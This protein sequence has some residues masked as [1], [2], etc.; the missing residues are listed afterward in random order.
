MSWMLAGYSNCGCQEFFM[1]ETDNSNYTIILDHAIFEISDDVFL[2]FEIMGSKWRFIGVSGNCVLGNQGIQTGTL[3]SS[4][5]V[6][7]VS[8][9]V[10]SITILVTEF[11][12]DIRGIK[13][14]LIGDPATVSIGSDT[15]NDIIIAGIPLISRHHVSITVSRG[16][17]TIVDKSK[18]GTFVNGKRIRE[19]SR[20]EYGD[21]IS[22]FGIQLIWLGNIIG[23]GGKCGQIRCTLSEIALEKA[24]PD[25][26][27]SISPKIEKHYFRRSPRNL[28][29]FYSEKIEIDAPPQAQK[30]SRRPLLLTIGP[31][32]T[33]TLP[34][35]LGTT[36]AIWGSRKSGA[37]A[38]LYMYTGI[39]IAVLSAVIGTIWALINLNYSKKQEV[40]SEHIRIKKYNDYLAG[41]EQEITEKYTYNYQ[42]LNYI[43]PSADRCARYTSSVPDLWNRNTSHDDFLFLRLGTGVLPFQCSIIAP[44]KKFSLQEDE[45]LTKS[46]ELADKFKQLKDAPLGIDLNDKSLVG[47]VGQSKKE[48]L[49]IM[50]NLVVQA[51]AN[52]CYTDLKMVFLFDGNTPSSFADWS[53]AKWLPHV[54]SPDRK[55]RYFASNKNERNEVCF[56]LANILRIRAEEDSFPAG[57]GK[58]A[59]HYIVFVSSPELLEGMPVAKYLL[60]YNGGLGVTTVLLADRFEQLP[61]G[62]VDI[63]ENNQEFSGFFNIGHDTE[64]RIHIDFD[65]VTTDD[66][67]RFA[68][69]ISAVEVQE[70]ESGSEIPESLTFL[71]MYHVNTLEELNISDRWAKNRTYETLR[72]PIGQKSGGEILSLDIHERFHG[73]HGLVAG[74]TGS[75]KSEV[76]QTYILSL[77]VNFSPNDVAF[78]LIDFKGGGMAN[79]FSNLPHIA[80]YIS[81]LSG[82]QI[83]RA[84]VSI[85]SENK[86][87]QRIFGEYGVNHI[88]QYTRLFKNGEATIPIPRLFIIID[89]FAELKRNEP[90]FMGELISVAQVGR[91]LGVHLILATQKPSG[92]V[93]DNIWSNTR[94]KLCL[95]VQD[96]QD[97]NDVLH[98]PDA[99]YLTQAGRCYM[100]IGNDEI[101]EL[102]QSGWSGAI[103]YDDSSVGK[104]SIAQLWSNIG[105]SAITGANRKSSHGLHSGDKEITQLSALV[106]YLA[107]TAD[108]LFASQER[109]RLW[110]PILPQE[111][112]LFDIFK[113]H[114]FNGEKWPARISETSLSVPVGVYD[115]P[116]NQAQA[117]LIVDLAA[118]GHLV[119]CGSVVSGK[120]TFVQT[121]LFALT[122]KYSPEYI[123]IYILDYS[124]HM[125]E[126]FSELAHVGGVVFDTQADKTEKLF[127]LLSNMIEERKKAFCGGSYT[128]YVKTHGQNMP[129]ILVVI[130][131]YANF[132]D[133]TENKYENNLIA[134]SREGANYGI[135]LI[136]TAGGFGAG[137]LQNR[138]AENFRSIVCLEMGDRFKYSEVLR[139]NH[140]DILPEGNVK[141]RGLVNVG[142]RI[143]EFQTAIA[144]SAA[145]DYQRSEKLKV[146]F[147]EMNRVWDGHRARHIPTIPENPTWEDF[148]QHN[149]EITS[150]S[151]TYMLPFA[152][153]AKDATIAHIDLSR[154]YC[155]LVSGKARTGKT[156]LLKVIAASAALL[157]SERYIVDFSGT[158]LRRFASENQAFYISDGNELFAALKELLAK[159]KE[160]NVQKQELLAA[161]VDESDIYE[162]MQGFPPI[163]LFVDSLDDFMKIIYT[164]PE[165]IGA[166]AGFIENITEKGYLHNIYI[167]AGYD[168]SSATHSV[169]R[170]AF[171]NFVSYKTG[172]HL[173]GNTAAQR[174]FDFSMIPYSEQSKATK[175]GTGLIPPDIYNPVA[176]SV[177]IPLLKG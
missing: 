17:C 102:F 70:T 176:Q 10:E 100:Q 26:A 96:K 113:E 53:F 45:L 97:S 78:F 173:G 155:W 125:L 42:N 163:F 68:R 56:S 27:P 164:P 55:C 119:I 14:Y 59:P 9:G 31:S 77:A 147:S 92:T 11:S 15:N 72:V 12:A 84:M 71:D 161:G 170:K 118:N 16:N 128:Q 76:L 126:P 75:G 143:L 46:V 154:T 123:N 131:N 149:A 138:I 4:G 89:E 54:W 24:A 153:N 38:G 82:N 47:I 32:L 167:I 99:A 60:G 144:I 156:T 20:I 13:K 52:I 172:I 115:D 105:L 158:K 177:I 120:S 101:Y 151:A 74:T 18:N 88:D 73:P 87:R 25:D 148:L 109:F 85:K 36:V 28:P 19:R 43:Y 91:S 130:D 39:I 61:N 107:A 67:E 106:N 7:Y 137:D 159:F 50:R 33:M 83:H 8:V 3:I 169:G 49:I 86:R 48:S 146:C 160:R 168:S 29:K 51:A 22:L 94:F 21:C 166:M 69:T 122:H 65:F 23:V 114:S 98:K 140:L 2:N 121:L 175:P 93:D 79:L 6:I 81:N 1:P 112:Y 5:D 64:T 116:A 37:S 132:R 111:I 127:V 34:M 103:Y 162:Q 124:N 30:V 41:I 134:I 136:L 152:W 117:P 133:K 62:C 129:Y 174:V 66:V 63:I 35:I 104:A 139:T 57:K 108:T 165:G 44:Q 145:D 157:A 58:K 80:G 171:T 142:G 90:E 141:G 110:L 135:Y 95:R 40:E 150:Q